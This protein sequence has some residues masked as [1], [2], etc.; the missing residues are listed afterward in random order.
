MWNFMIF[1]MDILGHIVKEILPHE[2]DFLVK[3]VVEVELMFILML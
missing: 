2:V 1:T 3:E